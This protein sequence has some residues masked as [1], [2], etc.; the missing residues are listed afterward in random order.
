[1]TEPV[2]ALT[3]AELVA[4]ASLW[5]RSGRELVTRFSGSSMEPTIRDAAHVRLS[6]DDEAGIGD[7]IAYV[8]GDRV[9]VH[10]I[11]ARW[12][13]RFVA[14]GDA[15]FLPDPILLERQQ[16]IGRIATEAAMPHS[17]ARAFVL[18][19]FSAAA[20]IF[21]V[22]GAIRLI[23]VARVIRRKRMLDSEKK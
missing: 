21:G 15:N 4:V 17:F 23:G 2:R 5:K 10:R 1:M 14:R 12:G 18:A 8:Y 22:R 3:N 7:V 19:L 20:R 11:V 13:D 6:C 9:I 16:I